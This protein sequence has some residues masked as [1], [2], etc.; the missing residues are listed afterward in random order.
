MYTSQPSYTWGYR[1]G[2]CLGYRGGPSGGPQT[3]TDQKTAT[4]KG[5]KTKQQITNTVNDVNTTTPGKPTHSTV[6]D[7]YISCRIQ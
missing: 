5:D 2:Q 6:G 1:A 7:D 4:V 3:Q